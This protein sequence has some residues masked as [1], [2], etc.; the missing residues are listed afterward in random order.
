MMLAAVS[1]GQ[2]PK[3]NPVVDRAITLGKVGLTGETGSVVSPLKFKPSGGRIYFDEF[4]KEFADDKEGRDGL[5][6]VIEAGV[7][8]FEAAGVAG[9]RGRG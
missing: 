7:Q 2:I 5:K 8:E 3:D 6:A 1:F 4:V 9:G